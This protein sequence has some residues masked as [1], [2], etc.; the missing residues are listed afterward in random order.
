MVRS[1]FGHSCDDSW[2]QSVE[3]SAQFSVATRR[4][5]CNRSGLVSRRHS[6]ETSRWAGLAVPWLCVS[7][8]RSAQVLSCRQSS[9]KDWKSCCW[10]KF[11]WDWAPF[12]QFDR[13]STGKSQAGW[14]SMMSSRLD[15][16]VWFRSGSVFRDFTGMIDWMYH[17]ISRNRGKHTANVSYH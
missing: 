3:R 17:I 4:C 7:H 5:L 15:L 10:V 11:W 16:K 8:T 2:P 9:Q 12:Q 13:I 1:N 6:A 14:M